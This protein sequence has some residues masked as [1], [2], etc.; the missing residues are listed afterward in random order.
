MKQNFVKTEIDVNKYKESMQS[1]IKK[2][3]D[4]ILNNI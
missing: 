1:L 2:D 4:I 3:I